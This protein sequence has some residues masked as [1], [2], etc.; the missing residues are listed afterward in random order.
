[1]AALHGLA[2]ASKTKQVCYCKL[3]SPI[4]HCPLGMSSACKIANNGF[5]CIEFEHC[6]VLL[7]LAAVD[8]PYTL[9]TFCAVQVLLDKMKGMQLTSPF[10]TDSQSAEEKC[11]S[12]LPEYIH[13]W[14]HA[15]T[16]CSALLMPQHQNTI[17]AESPRSLLHATLA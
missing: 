14:L 9:L 7:G 16:Y 6:V 11:L 10:M 4:L 8:D 1:M 3:N 17:P 15:L 5:S 12:P 2:S 13:K